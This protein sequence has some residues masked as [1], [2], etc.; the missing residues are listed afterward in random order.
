MFESMTMKYVLKSVIHGKIY[1]KMNTW[2]TLQMCTYL[3]KIIDR[4]L[5]DKQ[6]KAHRYADSRNKSCIFFC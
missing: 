2:T 3:K 4:E 6:W 5:E 1:V